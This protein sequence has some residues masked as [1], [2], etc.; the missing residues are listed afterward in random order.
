MLIKKEI[1][2]E[3]N[4][5]KIFLHYKRTHFHKDTFSDSQKKIFH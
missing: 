2:P 1:L 4:E 3:L 5:N